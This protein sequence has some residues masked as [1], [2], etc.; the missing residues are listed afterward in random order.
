VENPGAK[1]GPDWTTWTS[2]SMSVSSSDELKAAETA[3]FFHLCSL[4]ISRWREKTE[5][6]TMKIGYRNFCVRT[7]TATMAAIS[8]LGIAGCGKTPAP[9]EAAKNVL[10]PAPVAASAAKS[11]KAE[12]LRVDPAAAANATQAAAVRAAFA[13]DSR[14]KSFRSGWGDDCNPTP[15]VLASEPEPTSRR[16]N[17]LWRP[18]VVHSKTFHFC[19][20]SSFS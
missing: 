9:E 20:N 19:Q 5:E 1:Q 13:A 4:R 16:D 17:R 7:F 2:Q 12:P 14:L 10:P 11:Q 6:N 3:S 15:R 8:C 18:T